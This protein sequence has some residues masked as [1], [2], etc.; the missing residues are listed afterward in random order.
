MKAV[1][2]AAGFGSRMWNL[3]NKTPK[4]LL[5]FGD[6]SIL[7][8]IIRQLR[9]AGI[10]SLG[11]VVGYRQ[12]E[13]R[14]YLAS[15]DAGIPITFIEN[16][17]WERGNGIS[18]YKAMA[19]AD[20]DPIVLS[21]CDHLVKVTA[22]KQVVDEPQRTNLLLTDP[23]IHDNFDIDDATKVLTG[24]SHITSIG[25]EL[26][27]YN[28][29]DCGIFRLEADFFAA[30]ETAVARGVESISGAISELM[31]ARRIQAISLNKPNQWI[32]VDTPEAYEYA[33]KHFSID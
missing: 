23:F 3:S 20:G 13:I 8:T 1:I 21:M 28:A 18:V 25:K 11:L 29:L 4:T 9:C 26:K 14:D 32:D 27:E 2:I 5:P 31:S 15:Y 30:V 17:E 19:F 10:D 7:S 33:T 12:Q 24:G 22:I 16:T 6:G